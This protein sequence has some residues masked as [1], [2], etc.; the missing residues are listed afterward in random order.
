MITDQTYNTMT[1]LLTSKDPKG[2]EKIYD[3]YGDALYGIILRIV[4]NEEVATEI[5]QDTF[6]V[7]W[8]KG[9]TY[10]S[11]L[12]RIY[13]WLMRIA[14]NKSLN[15]IQSRRFKQ[16]KDIRGDE[17][18]VY[19][20]D[21][22]KEVS[23]M[24]SMDIKGTVNNLDAKYSR[25]IDLIYFQGFTHKEASD[26]LKLPLGTVKSQVKIAL[27]ELKKIHEF[28]L[29]CVAILSFIIVSMSI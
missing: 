20:S 5:L 25:V 14:R 28:R 13:T 8:Q 16:Q 26:E 6:I 22:A 11:A 1:T 4:R 9:D 7:A 27:R 17:N 29:S 15:Y 3:C 23:K 19:L 2:I 12:G 24:D 21:H 10:D 18:L